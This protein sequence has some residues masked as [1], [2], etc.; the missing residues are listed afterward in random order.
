M[1]EIYHAA[2]DPTVREAFENKITYE[3]ITKEM[4]K[5]FE[6]REPHVSI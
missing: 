4:D 5:M 6:S 1:I 2:R 3:R